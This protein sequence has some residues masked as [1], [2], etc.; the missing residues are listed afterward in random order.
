MTTK[1]TASLLAY[2]NLVQSGKIK[3]FSVYILEKGII[4]K[5]AGEDT[6]EELTLLQESISSLRG[7]FYDVPSVEY[8]SFDYANLKSLIN[9][10][11][12]LDRMAS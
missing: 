9:A 8:N 3:S 4:L 11:V 12:Y 5:A 7:F 2:E 1:V 6:L 10:S